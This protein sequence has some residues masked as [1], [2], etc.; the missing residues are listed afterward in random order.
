MFERDVFGSLDEMFDMNGDGLLD[1]LE[2][3]LEFSFLQDA[4]EDEEEEDE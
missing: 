4:L 3:G 2:E 1:S